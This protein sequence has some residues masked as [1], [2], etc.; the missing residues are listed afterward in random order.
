MHTVVILLSNN[1]FVLGHPVVV[2]IS[3]IAIVYI[4]VFLGIRLVP[5]GQSRR[6]CIFYFASSCL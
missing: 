4:E 2:S 3:E 6:A 5:S 1:G